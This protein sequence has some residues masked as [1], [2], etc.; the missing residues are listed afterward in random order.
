MRGTEGAY[1]SRNTKRDSIGTIA[2]AFILRALLIDRHVWNVQDPN[3]QTKHGGSV[4]GELRTRLEWRLNSRE[5]FCNTRHYYR[6]PDLHQTIFTLRRRSKPEAPPHTE[7]LLDLLNRI[8]LGPRDELL[9]T[10]LYKNS[11]LYILRYC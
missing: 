4:N 5:R 11:G 7:M 2:R 3:H 6:H 9:H 1:D 8:D 10:I